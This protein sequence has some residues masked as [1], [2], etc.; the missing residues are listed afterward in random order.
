MQD[1]VAD[2]AGVVGRLDRRLAERRAQLERR[3]HRRVRR[4]LAANELDER[5]ERH[6]VHEVHA[7]HA[8]GRVRT[9]RRAAVIEIDDVFDARITSGL[10]IASRL[11]EER[12]L[13]VGILDDRFDDVVGVGEVVDV[14]RRSAGGRAS[15]R[16][17]P[18]SACPSRRTSSRLVRSVARARSSIGSRDVDEPHGESGLREH[19][20]DAA[21]HRAR[22]NHADGFDIHRL[23]R[24]H[25]DTKITKHLRAKHIVLRGLRGFVM[26]L[27]RRSTASAT[28]LPPPR[29]SVA[30]PR[31]RFRCFER[32]EQRRQ[33]AA[34]LEPIA[35]PRATAP[36]LTLTFAGSRPSS[37]STATA[38]TEKASFSSN[39][40]TSLSAQPIFSQ[41]PADRFD[42]RHQHELRREA[43]RRLADDAGERR[44]AEAASRAR[45]PSRRAPTRRRSRRA[46]CRRSPC[47]PS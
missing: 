37:A 20:R 14:G 40:S 22:A 42:R 23:F 38:C 39:R 13:R 12:A 8:I 26:A 1:P 11:A 9:P 41:Q 27:R 28:P 3:L 10:A 44:E 36:P 45:R 15:C 30:M 17:R 4:R 7:E 19:L 6:R 46:R 29:Q 21:A 5:H 25:E 18:P 35:W 33:D 43:A 47:R 31:L 24:M 2:E 16:G 34:P 32:I